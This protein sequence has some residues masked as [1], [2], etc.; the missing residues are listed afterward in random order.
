MLLM[1]Y[2]LRHQNELLTVV[3]FD[4]IVNMFLTCVTVAC[5]VAVPM[6]RYFM[7]GERPTGSGW[8]NIKLP[9]L[10]RYPGLFCVDECNKLA[11]QWAAFQVV[12][13]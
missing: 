5:I 9:T 7:Q 4:V 12:A 11:M 8:R 13:R 2:L 3:L 1:V 6:P 10:T